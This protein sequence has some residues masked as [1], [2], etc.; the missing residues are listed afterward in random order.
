MPYSNMLFQTLFVGKH[1]S[2]RTKWVHQ[3]FFK[4]L[5]C[6][7]EKW[8]KCPDNGENG[9]NGENVL[10]VASEIVVYKFPCRSLR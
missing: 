7:S 3:H 2:L 1:C 6:A 8:G 4:I 10:T 9:E 5:S